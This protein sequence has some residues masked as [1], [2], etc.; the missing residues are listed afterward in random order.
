MAAGGK[1]SL[2]SNGGGN[3]RLEPG[4]TYNWRELNPHHSGEGTNRVYNGINVGHPK[5]YGVGKLPQFMPSGPNGDIPTPVSG[6]VLES[7]KIAGSGYG[8]S[9]VLQTKLGNM[10]YAHLSKI[11][12][13][14]KK[15]GTVPAGKIVGAPGG[16]GD[17]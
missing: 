3:K 6:K 14:I 16:D 4:K 8:K 13:G 17:R 9:V 12:E 11:G 5:D 10:H 15:G 1:I 7:G 2:T